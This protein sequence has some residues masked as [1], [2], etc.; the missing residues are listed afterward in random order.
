MQEITLLSTSGNISIV[1]DNCDFWTLGD[2]MACINEIYGDGL[3]YDFGCSELI[4]RFFK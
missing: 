4:F 2:R 1:P 3:I